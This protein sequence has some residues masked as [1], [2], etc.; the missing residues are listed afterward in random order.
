MK[1]TTYKII[2]YV[3]VPVTITNF[4][5]ATKFIDQE[6]KTENVELEY[7]IRNGD[8]SVRYEDHK[9]DLLSALEELLLDKPPEFIAEV[10]S[11]CKSIASS[12]LLR[13]GNKL[14]EL[15]Q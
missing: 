9:A 3:E 1:Y 15:N 4:I 13:L 14:K 6:L 11:K 7:R 2:G 12:D 8:P 10:I 5:D